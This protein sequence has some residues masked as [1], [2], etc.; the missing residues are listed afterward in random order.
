AMPLHLA[1][2][3][4]RSECV[5]L[6]LQA[7][8]EKDATDKDGLTPLDFAAGKGRAECVDLLLKAGAEK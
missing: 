2:R 8:A 4:G 1:A 5:D 3:D 6:L 7:G